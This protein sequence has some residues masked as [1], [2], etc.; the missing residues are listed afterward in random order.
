MTLPQRPVIRFHDQ[1]APL[2]PARI[3]QFD[4]P[5][6]HQRSASI[7]AVTIDRKMITATSR[8]ELCHQWGDQEPSGRGREGLN[9]S[10]DR[11]K[12]GIE[13]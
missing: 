11:F 13:L 12:R 2:P 9:Y 3:A 10:R 1:K 6:L 4:S 5:R 8:A 7:V